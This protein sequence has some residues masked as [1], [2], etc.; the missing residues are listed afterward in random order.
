M[1][2]KLPASDFDS[3][4]REV[5]SLYNEDHSKIK[6]A[7]SKQKQ[8]KE[9]RLLKETMMSNDRFFFVINMLNFEME[10]AHGIKKWLGYPEKDFTLK[11]YWN[12]VV[13]PSR[14][15][16]LL[17]I[18]R[19]MYQTLSKGTYPLEFMVQRFS[20]IV[21]LKHYN[22]HYILT[23]KT[24]SVFQYDKRNRL[25]AYMDEFTVINHEYNNEPLNPVMYNSHGERELI[26]EKEIMQKAMEHFISMRVFTTGELQAIRL[27]IDKKNNNNTQAQIAKSL[28]LSVHTID[29]YYKRF[30]SK[31]RDFYQIQFPTV[32][33]A[34]HYLRKEGL[35]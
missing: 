9:I 11:K 7:V 20:T 13:H 35:I 22:G 3:L 27:L 10:E 12:Q 19:Q 8:Q 2:A 14:K 18:V 16:S 30:L 28:N 6:F 4:Q 31:A 17:F 34:A 29:T 26:K 32:L 1:P 15:H 5:T 21:P 24:A 33:D 25:M 23:K